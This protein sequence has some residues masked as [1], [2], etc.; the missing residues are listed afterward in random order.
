LTNVSV[1]FKSLAWTDTIYS[2]GLVSSFDKNL[3]FAMKMPIVFSSD[4][5]SIIL[6]YPSKKGK[7]IMPTPIALDRSCRIIRQFSDL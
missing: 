4:S 2:I 7:F 3:S 1:S 5:N 6:Y